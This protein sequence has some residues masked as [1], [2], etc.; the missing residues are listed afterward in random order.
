[1]QMQIQTQTQTQKPTQMLG[2]DGVAEEYCTSSHWAE[3]DRAYH[4]KT[5]AFMCCLE[6]S[7]D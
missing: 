4:S 7:R 6:H 3:M 1:M 5:R 2:L